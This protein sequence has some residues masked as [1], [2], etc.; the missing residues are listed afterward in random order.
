[1]FENDYTVQV[2]RD[3]HFMFVDI[4]NELKSKRYN[5]RLAERIYKCKFA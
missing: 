4:S 5:K 2:L 3:E 1:V